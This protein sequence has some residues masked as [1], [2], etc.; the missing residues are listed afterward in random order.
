MR[1]SFIVLFIV[2]IVGASAQNALDG[3]VWVEGGA[4]RNPKS[5]YHGQSLT[6]YPYLGRP[7]AVAGFYIG[8]YEVTQKEWTEV[9]GSNPSKFRGDSLPVETVCWYDCIEYCN[10]RSV[11]ENL[12]PYYTIDPVHQDPSNQTAIDDMKWT[13]TINAGANG[14]RLPTEAEW[15]YAAGGGALSRGYTYSGSDDLAADLRARVDHGKA[16]FAAIAFG[17]V[18]RLP[19]EIDD[20]DFSYRACKTR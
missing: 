15:E 11:R 8:K 5:N 6:K 7:L 10:K 3:L 2:F 4:F 14:Y 18:E 9:M 13:V 16:R 1:K 20:V 12:K 17:G 19:V